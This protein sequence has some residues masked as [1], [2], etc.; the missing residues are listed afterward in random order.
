[1]FVEVGILVPPGFVVVGEVNR[2][3]S[4]NPVGVDV[5]V[6]ERTRLPN[7]RALYLARPEGMNERHATE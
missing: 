5:R 4:S 2:V 3:V 1:M 6:L 7:G